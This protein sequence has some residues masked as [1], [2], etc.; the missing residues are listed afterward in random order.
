[1]FARVLAATAAAPDCA[2]RRAGQQNTEEEA[3]AQLDYA[4]SRGVN[5]IDT[6]EM[7][8]VPSKAET[9]GR[10]E[11]YVGSW[12]AKRTPEERSR[13]IVATKVCPNT[14]RTWIGANR[15]DPP[16]PAPWK[17]DEAGLTAAVD[18]SLRRLQ[19]STID[20]YQIHWPDRYGSCYAT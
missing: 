4:V 19:T 15:H 13:L 18:A 5:F 14:E 9:Q 20:L 12:L 16:N 1:M 11:L 2:V 7:Y 10:T 6:A 17:L 8:P 3:H